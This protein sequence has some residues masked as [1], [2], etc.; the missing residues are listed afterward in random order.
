MA[1]SSKFD[2]SSGSPD[3]LLYSSGQRG[4]HSMIPMDRSGSFRESMET[5]ATSSLHAVPRNSSVIAQTDVSNFFQCLPFDSKLLALDHKSNH[6]ADLKR[7][8]AVALGFSPDSPANILKGKL[9][10]LPS[11]E[12]L[13]QVKLGLRECSRKAGYPFSIYINLYALLCFLFCLFS[14]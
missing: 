11:L 14:L 4:P 10:A 1:S 2:L 5:S 13:K 6:Q 3:R 7:S 8:I 12:G 9:V